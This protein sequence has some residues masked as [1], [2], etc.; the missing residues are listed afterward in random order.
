MDKKILITSIPSWNQKTGSNTLSSLFD[1]F[2]SE[3][4]AN[5][6]IAGDVPDNAVCSRYFHIDEL[7]VIKST[8][9]R[10][11]ETGR[12]VNPTPVIAMN[13]RAGKRKFKRLRLLLWARELAWKLGRW[14][15]PSLISFLDN[16]SPEILVFPIE[17]YPY[18]NRL[19]Q[20]IINHCQPK[21]VIGYL[22]DDNFTYKQHPYNIFARIE[23]FFVRRQ[24]HKL[25][26]QCNS[27]LA[28]SPKM[29]HECDAEFGVNCV[30]LTKPILNP[31]EFC[32]YQVSS[33]IKILYTG[34]LIIGRDKTIAKIVS[35]IKDLNHNEPKF[36]LDIY[37]QTAL[38]DKQRRRLC[39][40]GC[41]NVH[42]PVPQS[43]VAE[44]QRQADILLFV[45]SLADN[46]L[47]AR[48]SFSTKLTDYFAAGKC[49]WA[50]GN[51]DLG[52]ID[53]IRTEN[54]GFVST[55]DSEIK[56]VLRDIADNP[57]IISLKAKLSH[58]CGLRNHNKDMIMN[59]LKKLIIT[60]PH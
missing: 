8:F 24:V 39:V 57:S 14:K 31:S 43:Q 59:T 28:I 1:S 3:D 20:F 48:L 38:S 17:N 41:C 29:K 10:N 21:I 35:A 37:T 49:V 44:L 58:L 12:E 5:I 55:N 33:P 30:V 40:D 16:F 13:G 60:P 45:E 42:P 54:A 46:D 19:N 36:I 34:K 27:I 53:Y 18:F 47:T 22:W 26:A 9:L 51:A 2:D 15:S 4:L 25:V 32:E 56:S 52:P 23:R 7:S 6:Y 11:T 50:V